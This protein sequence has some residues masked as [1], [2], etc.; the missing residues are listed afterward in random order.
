MTANNKIDVIPTTVK[1]EQYFYSPGCCFGA[2][3]NYN[4]YNTC[5][6]MTTDDFSYSIDWTKWWRDDYG[7]YLSVLHIILKKS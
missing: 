4:R 2:I 6:S 3:N 5:L 7:G 1:Q